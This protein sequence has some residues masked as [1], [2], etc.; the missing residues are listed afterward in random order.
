MKKSAFSTT[1]DEN[2]ESDRK[3]KKNATEST[4]DDNAKVTEDVVV[5]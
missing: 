4:I 3:I 1:E 5:A 2:I